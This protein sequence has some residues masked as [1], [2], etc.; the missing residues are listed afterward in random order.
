MKIKVE[1][2]KKISIM[3]LALIV[4]LLVIYALYANRTRFYSAEIVR[5]TQVDRRRKNRYG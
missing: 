5:Y 3:L 4:S 2:I 1:K